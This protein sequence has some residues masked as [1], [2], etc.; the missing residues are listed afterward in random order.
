MHKI[1]R[2]F[3]T[4]SLG[5]II[6]SNA[7]ANIESPSALLQAFMPSEAF[8]QALSDAEHIP[9]HGIEVRT[10]QYF[11]T[12][13]SSDL[14]EIITNE[15]YNK[16]K[17]LNIEDI[18]TR[19]HLN[20]T[21][22]G[23]DVLY[24]VFYAQ[25]DDIGLHIIPI[26]YDIPMS[27][28]YTDII[29]GQERRHRPNKLPD[30]LKINVTDDGIKVIKRVPVHHLN[31]SA[32]ERVAMNITTEEFFKEQYVGASGTIAFALSVIYPALKGEACKSL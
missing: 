26:S 11:L 1:K 4:M 12:W 9:P 13:T 31:R 28:E 10:G 16:L 15:Y 7:S 24:E 30:N 20:Q 27:F 8:S 25:R 6:A 5:A 14:N 21:L 29:T 17:D 22:E 2:Y 19:P 18:H 23:D 32:I 3:I